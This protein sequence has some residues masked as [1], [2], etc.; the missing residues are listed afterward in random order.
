MST[1]FEEADSKMHSSTKFWMPFIFQNSKGILEGQLKELDKNGLFKVNTFS[2]MKTCLVKLNEKNPKMVPIQWKCIEPFIEEKGESIFYGFK[3]RRAGRSRDFYVNNTHE[4]DDWLDHL[5]NVSIMTD[6]EDDFIF[7]KR[8]GKGRFSHVFLVTERMTGINFAVK[9]IKKTLIDENPQNMIA[10]CDEITILR[11]LDHPNILKLHKVY[12]SKKRIH[13]VLNYV[14]GGDLLTLVKNTKNISENTIAKFS[15][16]LLEVLDYLK[17]ENIAHR[18]I[19]LE[20]ILI[21]SKDNELDFKLGDF[22][23]ATEANGNMKQKCGS[24]GYAA[25][26]ILRNLPYNTKV[27]IFSAGVVFYILLSHKMPFPGKNKLEII[28]RNKECNV[29]FRT[30]DWENVSGAAM[31]FVVRLLEPRQEW[32]MSAEDALKHPWLKSQI[33]QDLIKES[34]LSIKI[35]FKNLTDRLPSLVCKG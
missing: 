29:C 35:G 8:L 10:L 18:D 12:E 15:Y 34:S 9:S 2:L 32:R 24:P 1:V 33:D 13:M 3:I 14:E 30:K 31:N 25:P 5:S 28:K 19:K 6:I 26:E 16:K 21:S 22:G 11:K 7:K 4:L 23:L 17:S 20:N 27:D